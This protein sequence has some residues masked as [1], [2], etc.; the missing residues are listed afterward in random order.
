MANVKVVSIGNIG[1]IHIKK[2][3]NT[4]NEVCKIVNFDPKGIKFYIFDENTPKEKEI[5]E[6]LGSNPFIK[7]EYELGH[8]YEDTNSIHISLQAVELDV[9]NKFIGLPKSPKELS[10][11][12]IPSIKK[13]NLKNSSMVL[14]YVIIDE[15]A[16]AKTKMDHGTEEYDKLLKYWQNLIE[17][18]S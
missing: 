8:Y 2:L 5:A 10:E 13:F 7:K 6:I 3:E 12:N 18:N 17:E 16:H 9:L 1:E 11:F 4:I 14:K 15:L